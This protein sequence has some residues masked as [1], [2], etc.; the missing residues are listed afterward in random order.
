MAF[1]TALQSLQDQHLA[2]DT[3]QEAFVQAWRT[4]PQLRT[5]AAFAGWLRR[6]V[7]RECSRTRRARGPEV[8]ASAMSSPLEPLAE[9]A[10]NPGPEGELTAMQR[11]SL[12]RDEVFALREPLR[13]TTTLF[14]FADC[15]VQE[16]AAI[17][18]TTAGAVRKRLHDARARLRPILTDQEFQM[19]RDDV[20]NQRPSSSP[21]F[22]QRVVDVLAAAATGDES[23]LTAL[24]NTD[25][26]LA[27]ARGP[28]PI[29]GGE[30]QALHLAAERNQL[31]A[32]RALLA[33]GADVDGT[34]ADYDGWSPLMLAAHGGRLGIHERRHEIVAGLLAHDATMDIFSAAVLGDDAIIAK[35]LTADPTLA[36]TTGPAGAT[37]LHFSTSATVSQQL[38][39]AGANANAT[40]GWGTTA[41]ERASF[42]GSAG[43]AVAKVLIDAGAH[44]HANALACLGDDTALSQALDA[45]PAAL[46][47][48]QKVGASIVGTPLHGA[49]AHGHI[50]TTRAL[51]ARGANVN[52]RAD[53]GQTPLHLA[54]SAPNALAMVQMLVEAD[55]DTA[56]KDDEHGT[57]PVVWAQFFLE[58]LDPDNAVLPAV[59]EYLADN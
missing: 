31:A 46:N 48:Q 45:D 59:I 14:Y 39:A 32:V 3:V 58:H 15:S 17:L 37:A 4:L 22:A 43:R 28:H 51:L 36:T 38:L 55:A 23:A 41:L 44:A 29:W 30:P 7:Q 19:A 34:D 26:S 54:V 27:N 16:V 11:R 8:P 2:E 40:C 42:R 33:G 35:L 21:A 56:A 53:L 52:A 49:V 50:T 25:A 10:T 47:A 57:P 18:N 9:G 1:V 13:S 20:K 6:I 24:L 12:I 5:P